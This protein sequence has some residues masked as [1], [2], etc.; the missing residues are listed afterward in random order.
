MP[1]G[2][3]SQP[4]NGGRPALQANDIQIGKM[5]R[6]KRPRKMA[7]GRYNDRRVDSIKDGKVEYYPFGERIT[8]STVTMEE[9][10]K[11]ASHEVF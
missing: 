6:A 10:L 5:Y 7:S 9:F 11:W 3:I 1:R 8:S 2:K 4:K